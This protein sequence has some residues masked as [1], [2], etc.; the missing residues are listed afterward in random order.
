LGRTPAQ[1]NQRFLT[2]VPLNRHVA[3]YASDPGLEDVIHRAL[4]EVGVLERLAPT[5]RVAL[6]PNL[7]YP[8]HRPGITTSP[9]VIRA[10]VAVLR[11]YTRHIALVETDGGYGT[12]KA[13][14]AFT[15]HGLY[16]LRDEFGVEVVNLCEEPSQPIAFRSGWRGY[17][18][19][20]PV[21]LLSHTDLFITLPVPKIHCMTGVS[22]A[23]KNQWGCVPDIMRL[24]RH[25]IFDE[26]IVAI[27]QALRPAVLA[28]GTFMLDDNGPMDGH[29]VRMDVIIAADSAGS[30]DRYVSEYM[31]VPWRRV[32]HLRAAVAAGDMPADLASI[33]YNIAPADAQTHTFRLHRTFRNYIALAGF[34]SRFLT[35]FGYESWFGRV[36]LHGILYAIAG[37]PVKPQP[38]PGK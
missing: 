20:L 29:P 8:Y 31:G 6:K 15:G 16:A 33:R 36:V 28:D 13:T 11:E 3:L 7:T 25:Y 14:E 10:T 19:P 30:F 22:L 26:A 34:R 12:W 9:A 4:G 37:R 23:Y 5:S 1:G 21:R 35:W 18:V 32:G 2:A 17:A 27:N 24:R 38:N